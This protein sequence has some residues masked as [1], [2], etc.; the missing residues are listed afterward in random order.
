[1][2]SNFGES[3]VVTCFLDSAS[4]SRIPLDSSKEDNH[5]LSV[6]IYSVVVVFSLILVAEH[7]FILLYR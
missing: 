6:G 3:D 1:M 7:Q 2:S 4:K 5:F